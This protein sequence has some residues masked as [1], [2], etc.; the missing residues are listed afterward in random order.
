M[1]VTQQSHGEFDDR[2]N[3]AAAAAV[4]IA[5]P[6]TGEEL[7]EDVAEERA[8]AAVIARRPKG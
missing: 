7:R 4:A 6:A 3:F 8:T 1:F 5:C 2:P